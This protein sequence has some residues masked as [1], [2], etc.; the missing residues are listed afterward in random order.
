M[1]TRCCGDPQRVAVLLSSRI[2]KWERTHQQ[3]TK[4]KGKR[5][6]RKG[7][8]RRKR[9]GRRENKKRIGERHHDLGWR[10]EKEN[11]KIER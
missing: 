9:E 6:K 4:V 10:R 5:G 1:C 3:L 7:R 11:V 2:Q 8:D